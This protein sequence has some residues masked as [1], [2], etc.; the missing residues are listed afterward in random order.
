MSNKPQSLN[1]PFAKPNTEFKKKVIGGATVTWIDGKVKVQFL[2]NPNSGKVENT[3]TDGSTVKIFEP[4]AFPFPTPDAAKSGGVIEDNLVVHL[5]SDGDAVEYCTPY[6]WDGLSAKLVDFSRPNGENTPPMWTEK[7]AY[8]E[9]QEPVLEFA[10]YFE[11]THNP[12]F[13]GKR[14]RQ[15]QHYLFCD[16]GNGQA[17]WKFK[18][19]SST[20]AYQG[21][22][23]QKLMDTMLKT[24]AIPTNWPEVGIA[25]WPEDGNILPVLLQRALK[26]G[27]I[28]KLNFKNGW[29]DSISLPNSFGAG[30]FVAVSDAQPAG[31]EVVET[32]APARLNNEP[33]EM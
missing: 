1:T 26:A 8:K 29:I 30:D 19:V 33:D 23:T 32:K 9:G 7:P 2:V 4:S 15:T 22:W 25:E 27:K 13:K 10:A 24:G 17:A 20:Q 21:I 12:F 11:F 6:N 18:V 16:N 14:V 5:N 28:V 31:F 3:W